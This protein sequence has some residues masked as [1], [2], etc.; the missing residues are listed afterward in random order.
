MEKKIA[1]SQIETESFIETKKIIYKCIKII[2]GLKNSQ[3]ELH[4]TKQ[5]LTF[6]AVYCQR[7]K[8]K[9]VLC[10]MPVYETPSDL[11]VE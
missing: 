11:L 10:C 1:K 3:H 6:V 5:K 2:R 7:K 9:L 8:F 4:I